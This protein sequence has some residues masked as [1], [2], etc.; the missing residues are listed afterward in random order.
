M[1][2]LN[3]VPPIVYVSSWSA[4]AGGGLASD[5][6]KPKMDRSWIRLKDR[7]SDEYVKGIQSFM[8]VAKNYTDA[9]QKTLCPCR[10]CQNKNPKRKLDLI[11]RHLRSNG[12]SPSYQVWVHHGEK[13]NLNDFLPH[14]NRQDEATSSMQHNEE[15]EPDEMFEMIDSLSLPIPIDNGS[16]GEPM[17]R[18]DEHSK[19]DDC[20][21]CSEPRYI[22]HQGKGKKVAQK[23]LRYFPL[24]PRLQRLFMSKHTASAMRWHKDR[25][26]DKRVETEDMLRHPTDAKGWKDFDGKYEQF[27][28]D[29]RNVRLG[30]ATDGFNPFV[31]MSNSYSM[32]PV[33]LIPDQGPR[34]RYRF[35]FRPLID[36]LKELWEVGADTFD[37]STGKSFQMHAAVILT[38]NDFPAFGNLSSWSTKGY[39]A[40]PVCNYESSSQRLRSKIGY[41]GHRRFLPRGHSWRRSKQFNGKSDLRPPPKELNGYDIVNQLEEFKHVELG[42]NPNRKSKKR[43]RSISDELNWVKKSIFFEFPYWEFL[44]IRHKLD[45]MHIEKNICDNIMGT[46]LN[47]DKKTKDTEKARLD[48]ADMNIRSELHLK[49]LGDKC[50]KPRASYA[51]TPE[52]RREFCKFLKS[53]KFPDGIFPPAFFDVMVHLAVHLTHEAKIAG[54]VNYNWMYPIERFLGSLKRFVKNKARPEGSIAEGYIVKE[55]LTYCSLY[56]RGIETKFNREERKNDTSCDGHGKKGTSLPVFSQ[57]ACPISGTIYKQLSKKEI[58]MGHCKHMNELKA[59]SNVNLHQRQIQE[60]PK[61]F[62]RHV[63]ALRDKGSTDTTDELYFIACGPDSRVKSYSGCIVNGVR[64]FTKSRDDIRTTQNSGLVV[65]GEHEGKQVD[66]Y[67]ILSDILELKYVYPYRVMLFKCE[68]FD[69]DPKKKRVKKDYNLTC[70]D[71]S[72]RWYKDDPFVLA[73]GR[74]AQQVFYLDDYKFGSNWKVAERMQHRHLWDVPELEEVEEIEETETYKTTEEAYQNNEVSTLLETVEEEDLDAREFSRHDAEAEVVDT[75]IDLN[76]NFIYDVESDEEDE[77]A[78]EYIDSDVEVILS[79]DEM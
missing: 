66:F 15:P 1:S 53:V 39:K 79:D 48:L 43:K 28:R 49:V 74:Q 37:A 6:W 69:L 47:L 30:L 60:L 62:K 33:I 44:R 3:K 41:L 54:P 59:Q 11:E 12:F 14:S 45:V 64:F 52:Q 8:A 56:L 19:R 71:V 65:E 35:V 21:V 73:D 26:K 18:A 58:E 36:E 51:L 63:L 10:S 16:S 24:K 31:N 55:S 50:I 5:Y 13:L 72:G 76:D 32:W 2:F 4:S 68:W 77:T 61:W 17:E 7:T 75:P 25:H 38:I 23:V 42:K 22:F 34:K 67:G 78:V 9:E 46:L 20:P 70:I 57:S 27:A 29:P 40:C